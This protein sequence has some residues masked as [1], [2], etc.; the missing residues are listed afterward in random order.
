VDGLRF[1]VF[2]P[3]NLERQ[4]S[5]GGFTANHRKFALNVAHRL[6][7][8]AILLDQAKTNFACLIFWQLPVDD[9]FADCVAHC[10]LK[11][12]K[13]SIDPMR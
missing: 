5:K 13:C 8:A 6:H 7:L 10:A 3:N 11:F 12:A 4:L 1:A 2:N 9:S